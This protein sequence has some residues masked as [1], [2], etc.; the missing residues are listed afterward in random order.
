MRALEFLIDKTGAL[1]SP[2]TTSKAMTAGVVSPPDQN[3]ITLI[4]YDD[5]ETSAGGT[6]TPIDPV[7]SGLTGTVTLQARSTED[8]AWSDIEGGVLNL[9]TD[10]M[11]FPSGV[12]ESILATCDTVAGCEYILIR[13]DRGA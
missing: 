4:F 10:N 11:C 1:I 8:S 12:I 9:A 2:T 6:I 13:F 7:T 3:Q 5:I